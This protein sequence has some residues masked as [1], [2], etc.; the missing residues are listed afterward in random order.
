MV[1]K[2]IE[3]IFHL[4]NFF[5]NRIVSFDRNRIGR[6][7]LDR[8]CNLDHDQEAT[9]SE[10]DRRRRLNRENIV[11]EIKKMPPKKNCW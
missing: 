1:L 4:R 8:I 6:P 10:G 11:H 5:H 3:D 7:E 2:S 9:S